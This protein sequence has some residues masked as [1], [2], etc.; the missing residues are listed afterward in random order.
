MHSEEPVPIRRRDN[1]GDG[2][3]PSHPIL[4]LLPRRK[5]TVFAQAAGDNPPTK[6]RRQTIDNTAQRGRS[7][8]THEHKA[9]RYRRV[10]P[11]LRGRIH[12]ILLTLPGY[13]CQGLDPFPVP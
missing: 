4:Q 7:R 2:I 8:A 13:D 3:E 10:P 11:S 12:D 1:H 5:T 6:E 9:A